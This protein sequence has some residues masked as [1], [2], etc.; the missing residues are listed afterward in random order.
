MKNSYNTYKISYK[1]VSS[2][3]TY[4]IG[5]AKTLICREPTNTF[6]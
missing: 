1:I 3:N 6:F 4:K 2:Y 5:G